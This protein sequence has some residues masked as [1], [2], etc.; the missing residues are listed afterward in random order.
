MA[1]HLTYRMS[2]TCDNGSDDEIS[3]ESRTIG[4]YL[5]RPEMEI[6]AIRVHEY[7]CIKVDK[8]DN[9]YF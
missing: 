8:V 1:T 5:G 6:E 3:E 9:Q 7:Q 4:T 2:R